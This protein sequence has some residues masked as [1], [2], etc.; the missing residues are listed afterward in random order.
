MQVSID[1]FWQLVAASEL[2]SSAET[3][4]LRQGFSQLKGVGHRATASLAAEWLVGEKKLTRYQADILLSGRPGPFVFGPFTVFDRVT[5]GRL[6][7]VFRARYE[8]NQQV[9]LLPLLELTADPDE[10]S[11][12]GELAG[13]C[14][15][16]KSP[17]VTRTYRATRQRGQAFVLFE[18][19]SGQTL[20]ES[21]GG[22]PLPIPTACQLAVQISLGLVALHEQKLVHGSIAPQN[23]WVTPQGS[24][25]IMQFPLVAPAARARVFELPLADYTAPELLERGALPTTLTDV[26]SLGCLVFQLLAG[27]PPFAGGGP[28]E[29]LLRHRDEIPQRLDGLMKKLPYDLAQIVDDMLQKD[30]LLRC[31]SAS[32]TA[33]VLGRFATAGRA[34]LPP[35]SAGL[36]PG[37]GAWQAPAWSEPPKQP[38]ALATPAQ[39]IAKQSVPKPPSSE[40]PAANASSSAS[41]GTPTKRAAIE[42]TKRTPVSPHS[43]GKSAAAQPS[44]PAPAPGTS[45]TPSILIEVPDETSA[46]SSNPGEMPR[47]VTEPAT[48]SVRS[49]RK[50][51]PPAGVWWT[52]IAAAAVLVVVTL[53]IVWFQL[54]GELAPTAANKVAPIPTPELPADSVPAAAAPAAVE[55]TTANLISDD[56]RTLW[57]SPTDGMPLDLRFLPNGAQV[58]VAWRPAELIA[59][60]EGPKIMAALGPAAAAQFEQLART[61]GSPL[62]EVERLLI[63]FAA[64]ESLS[65]RASYVATLVGE[66]DQAALLS[67]WGDPAPA[68]R[69]GKQYFE[70]AGTA[71]YLP[72]SDSR[73]IVVSS[74]TWMPE[75]LEQEGPPLLRSSLEQLLAASDAQRTFTLLAIP[76][77]VYTDGNSLVS[78]QLAPLLAPLRTFLGPDVEAV[79]LSAHLDTDL[80]IEFRAIAPVDRKP[81]TVLGDLRARWE[82]LPEHVESYLVAVKPRPHAA[83]VLRHFPAMLREARNFTRSGVESRELVMSTYLPGVAAHNLLLGAELALAE[84]LPQTA[85]LATSPAPSKTVS[86]TEA[87]ARKVTL[88]FPRDTLEGALGILAREI[89]LPI[90]IQGNDLQLEGIT[91]NQSLN[92]FEARGEPAAE[93]LRKLLKLANPDGKLVYQVKTDTGGQATVL[94]TTRAA[95]NRRGEQP[96]DG[97]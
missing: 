91:R 61:L 9:M 53:G 80:Y 13:L 76:G 1:D 7:R 30:P 31:Q 93:I 3:E 49:P 35:G 34:T 11:Q 39:P 51:S 59:S 77:F 78:G 12:F 52:M 46:E 65:P 47:V 21:L 50:S 4:T 56:G 23:I 48:S 55:G 45:A 92:N 88:S 54:P 36:T 82:R 32:E 84:H 63:A 87:L 67:A 20:I 81:L 64:D 89:D 90:V 94:V 14:A 58:I 10:Y 8:A 85:P 25:K 26:Y 16:V 62:S 72:A 40:Q 96:A 73:M 75:I 44:G 57:E 22:K 2:Y 29:K 97:F 66:A 24:L 86:A 15:A 68:E 33:H 37:Y 18:P 19:L 38:G 28:R 71:W 69:A 79:S 27:R 95:V 74:A 43:A 5:K 41:S 6:E 17:H 60:D 83:E 70:R 42:K